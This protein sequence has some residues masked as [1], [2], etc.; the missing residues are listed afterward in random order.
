M[1]VLVIGALGQDGK[2][3][4][5]IHK[6]QGDQVF[7]VIPRGR[8]IESRDSH[9]FSTDLADP[10]VCL[11]LLEKIRPKIIYHVAAIHGSALTQA[12]LVQKESKAIFDCTISITENLIRWIK[13]H[14]E[15]RFHITLSSQMYTPTESE[16]YISEKSTPNPRN[17]YAETKLKA[18]EILRRYRNDYG[19]QLNASILFNHSSEW[20][21][22]KFIFPTLVNKLITSNFASVENLNLQNPF[23][24][25]DMSDA[26]EICQAITQS[27]AY[28][29][30]EDFVL[31]S[32]RLVTLID[33]IEYV[34]EKYGHESEGYSDWH[35]LQGGKLPT[36]VSDISKAANIL[37]WKPSVSPFQL[38]D[39]MIQ[40]SMKEVKSAQ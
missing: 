38:I 14:P 19:L 8:K 33:V 20:N 23:A 17:Y 37:S 25:L 28:D 39:R 22:Q 10:I 35:K 36:L 24:R 16:T 13:I 34:N 2:L 12:D 18:W 27:T 21:S 9:L 40:A 3:I 6:K 5:K 30:S 32:G 26:N 11:N 4:T 31:G 15:N 1:K 29:T 7:G